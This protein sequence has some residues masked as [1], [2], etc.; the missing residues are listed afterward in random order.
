VIEL[1]LRPGP[2]LP[3]DKS[4][5]VIAGAAYAFGFFVATFWVSADLTAPAEVARRRTGVLAAVLASI[6]WV[7]SVVGIGKMWPLLPPRPLNLLEAGAAFGFGPAVA[8]AVAMVGNIGTA[9]QED[10]VGERTGLRLGVAIA[11]LW[12]GYWLHGG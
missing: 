2:V 6:V 10:V 4:L 1:A 3:G 5:F 8:N 12:L 7:A 11:F 9:E